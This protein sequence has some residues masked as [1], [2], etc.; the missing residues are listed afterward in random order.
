VS[1]TG[2]QSLAGQVKWEAT[3]SGSV[4]RVEF[5]LDNAS[6]PVWT[7]REAPY[8]FN[9]DAGL[10]DTTKL[11]DGAHVLGLKAVGS[12]GTTG[13]AKVTLNVANAVPTTT[14]PATP[15]LQSMP[16]KETTE[17]SASFAFSTSTAGAQLECALDG[18]A[19]AA[20]ASPKS[21]SGLTV[22]L[23]T[24]SARA[25]A[26]GVA[27]AVAT[28]SW[29]ITAPSPQPSTCASGEWKAEFFANSTLSSS[30]AL[31]RCDGAVSFDWGYGQPAAS[32]PADKF[33]AR[34]VS[35]WT[36]PG[37]AIRFTVTG[38]DGVR[39]LIDGSV[40]LDKWVDQS[41][42]TYSVDR[43]MSTGSHK[44][45]LEYYENTG[46]ATAKLSWASVA[47]VAPPTITS[48]PTNPTTETT[49]TFAFTSTSGSAFECALDGGSYT[50]CSSPKSYSGL[51]AGSHQFLVRT[52]A[53]GVASAPTAYSWQVSASPTP[54]STGSVSFTGDWETGNIS[55]WTWG[56][57]C[58][59][60]GD[61]N[62]LGQPNRGT[63]N[64][65]T[66]PVAQGTYAAKIDLPA[67]NGGNAC[68]TLRKRTLNLGSDDYYGIDYYFPDN[69]Q[70]PSS[71]GWGMGIAQ[72]NYQLVWGTPVGLFAHGDHV[73]L[74]TQSGYCNDY[75][76]ANPGCTYSSGVGGNLPEA[77]V[78]P[79]GK[80][81]RGRWIQIV[82][83]VRWSK[84]GTGVVE[85]WYR[86]R[87]DAAWNK[88]VDQRGYPTVQWSSSQPAPTDQVTS[89][90]VGA[91]RGA[92]TFPLSIWNDNFR[93]GSS[94]SAVS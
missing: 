94:F 59:N 24:F 25:V 92:A 82:V 32:V 10:L 11:A 5:F 72:F 13:E 17:T 41:P 22:G 68:E 9:G 21:Y 86:Y 6:A 53:S 18:A 83:H 27:S 60:V 30:P 34:W 28:Y 76:S 35:T 71:A 45:A 91:Y 7:E 19:L 69:W 78:V 61:S 15:V 8:V 12:D 50:S 43:T 39:L 56:A 33:S 63:L 16:A 26:G 93:V 62:T 80:L 66:S 77:A 75:L 88:T 67:Y 54:L 65:V 57:Q 37:G 40:V 2:G 20:C 87:G 81:V 64:L 36:F 55:Q 49:A 14:P 79:R 73:R 47:S 74:V 1:P 31:T 42:T 84:D 46:G 48:R 29:T 89:D 23:H 52:V 44:V 3:A 51:S 38:D 85:G 90:K 70:E 58:S 4:S